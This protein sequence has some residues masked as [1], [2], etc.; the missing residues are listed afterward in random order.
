[1]EPEENSSKDEDLQRGRHGPECELGN[2][3]WG[4]LA[5]PLLL[6][7]RDK[8]EG[9]LLSSSRGYQSQD[10]PVSAEIIL[11]QHLSPKS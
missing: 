5:Q 6:L 10:V 7:T 3:V 9:I 8:G 1:M 2:G 4:K 11:L